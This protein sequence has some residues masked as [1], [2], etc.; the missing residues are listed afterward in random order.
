MNTRIN[1]ESLI[2]K[3]DY[4][5]HVQLW[6][7]RSTLNPEGWLTNFHPAELDHAIHLLNSFM[8]FSEALVDQ[9][10]IAGFQTLSRYFRNPNDSLLTSQECWKNFLARVRFTYVTGETPSPTDSG[11]AF[12]RKARQLL[13][14]PEE[15]IRPPDETV[16]HLAKGGPCPVVFVDDFV[17][18]GSQFLATWFRPINL[19]G[20][21]QITFSE[22]SRVRGQA[23]YY[24]PLL[25]CHDGL[26]LL[27]QHAPAVRFNPCHVLSPK[28]SALAPDSILWPERLL[29]TAANFVEEASRRADIPDTNGASVNDWQGFRK[30]GLAVA[31]HHSVP[32]AT[33][34][35]FYWEQKGWK[36]LIRKT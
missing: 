13:G 26:Q 9:M 14:I 11:F 17:G 30:L 19:E 8:F 36:P 35:I 23:F 20:G 22:L 24:C 5:V 33:M 31:F 21:R 27:R 12:A 34:P 3:C 15:R 4:F 18:T 29:S 6:P 10:F 32:D 25:C 1:Q 7:L 28:H 16:G 2:A